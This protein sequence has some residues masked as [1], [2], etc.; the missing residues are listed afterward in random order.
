MST[1]L[2]QTIAAIPATVVVEPVFRK[3][4]GLKRGTNE[5][6]SFVCAPVNSQMPSEYHDFHEPFRKAINNSQKLSLSNGE[7]VVAFDNQVSL[8]VSQCNHLP[9]TIYGRQP[10]GLFWVAL[11]NRSEMIRVEAIP[12]L[13]MLATYD[14]ERD[15]SEGALSRI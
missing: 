15:E 10:D 7:I 2:D 11:L 8:D 14:V 3:L 6:V 12:H 1:A 9:T 13:R 5:P 4:T